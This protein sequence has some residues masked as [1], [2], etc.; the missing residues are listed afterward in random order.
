MGIF[1]EGHI[2]GYRM[3]NLDDGMWKE[4]YE[5]DSA[6]SGLGI[7]VQNCVT[8]DRNNLRANIMSCGWPN[9]MKNPCRRAWCW[10]QFSFQNCVAFL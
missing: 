1:K 9:L 5:T 10:Q 6:V 8:E 2:L 3:Q 7:C 4:E